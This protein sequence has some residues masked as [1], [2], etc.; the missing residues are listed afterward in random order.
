[1]FI[2]RGM[3]KDVINITE[4]Y[5]VIKNVIMLFAAA[6]TDLKCILQSE[7]CQPEKD[8]T[9]HYHLYVEYKK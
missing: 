1:M 8:H 3:D 5:S 6:W 9:V 2:N 4:Y 7:I